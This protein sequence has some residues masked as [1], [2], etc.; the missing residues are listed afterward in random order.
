[1]AEVT[2]FDLRELRAE[3]LKQQ[4]RQTAA[5]ADAAEIELRSLRDKERDRLVMGGRTRRLVI[6]QPIGGGGGGMFG[7]ENLV[8]KWIDALDHWGL[9]D[10]GEPVEIVIDS[11]G[12]SV[13]D[14]ISLFDS[15]LRLRRAGHHVTTRGR[16]MIAS[17][18]AVL[19]QSGDERT[20]D[21][22]AQLMIHEI[23]FGAAGKMSKM[24]EDV[25]FGKKLEGRLLDILAERSKLTKAQIA[26]KWKKTDWWMNAEEALAA[27]FID[28]IE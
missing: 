12:G 6:D 8:P 2:T 24:E 13:F 11:P 5:D 17:M 14:G 9:R 10:P 25:A 3:L 26:R 15:I 16:G 19:L 28:V 22:N 7:G 4:I 20:M 1:M 21:A 18:A 23:S 27:G